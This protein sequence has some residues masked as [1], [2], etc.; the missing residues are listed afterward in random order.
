[1]TSLPQMPLARVSTKKLARSGAGFRHFLDPHVVVS[2][3]HRRPH[4]FRHVYRF[5]RFVDQTSIQGGGRAQIGEHL[6][7]R[8]GA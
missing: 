8:I 1:M 2:V 4:G 6:M 3:I 7:G 5:L